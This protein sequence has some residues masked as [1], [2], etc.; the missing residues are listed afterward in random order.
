MKSTLCLAIMLLS[1]ITFTEVMADWLVI[2]SN[3]S[4]F[5]RYLLLQTHARL[6]LTAGEQLSLINDS[7]VTLDLK[8]P[9]TVD[10]STLQN[11]D[12]GTAGDQA[13][14]TGLVSRLASLM[15]T[16][17]QVETPG[18]SRSVTAAGQATGQKI[19]ING[20]TIRCMPSTDEV[21]F[22]RTHEQSL[23]SAR[24]EIR[25]PDGSKRFRAWY[26]GFDTLD[27]GNLSDSWHT[28]ESVM[29]TVKPSQVRTWKLVLHL[30]PEQLTAVERLNLMT[31]AGCRS[32]AAYLL[33]QL[34]GR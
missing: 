29:V 8:G 12:A 15:A 16:P 34:A 30:V 2:D 6:K 32:D 17:E 7:G 20:K 19:D 5:P 22:L 28:G 13:A 21:T 4:K 14:D 9:R 11:G 24:V 18:T 26:A 31:A 23:A 1:L 25:L 3:S 10:L 27:L 33:D